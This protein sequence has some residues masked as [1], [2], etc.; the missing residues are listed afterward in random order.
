MTDHEMKANFTAASIGKPKASDAIRAHEADIV[1][2]MAAAIAGT[3]PC[4][5]GVTNEARRI[6]NAV[7]AM[8]DEISV[9]VEKIA[10]ARQSDGIA[11]VAA[12]H[13]VG[14]SE[15]P[16][17]IAAAALETVEIEVEETPEEFAARERAEQ[18]AAID[19]KHA[20]A[21]ELDDTE[22]QTAL[23]KAAGKKT[24]LIRPAGGGVSELDS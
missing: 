14:S 11:F 23:T 3:V 8:G 21:S 16:E 22:K 5:D 10:R 17:D 1:A 24:K 2:K 20:E 6:F 15:P 13:P 12:E 7:L 19:A 4:G 9:T 18:L